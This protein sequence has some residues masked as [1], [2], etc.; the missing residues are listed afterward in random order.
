MG[1]QAV[2]IGKESKSIH[3]IAIKRLFEHGPNGVGDD[4]LLHFL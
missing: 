4:D 2:Q 3:A 1:S